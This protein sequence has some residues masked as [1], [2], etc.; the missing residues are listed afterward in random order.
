MTPDV[1]PTI[2]YVNFFLFFLMKNN[3]NWKS[4]T[5][6]GW[7]HLMAEIFVEAFME[8]GLAVAQVW[9]SFGG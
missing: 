8:P 1:F 7:K 6:K 2:H 9:Q 5:R 3:D 4:P